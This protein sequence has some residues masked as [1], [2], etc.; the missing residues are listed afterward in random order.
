MVYLLTITLPLGLGSFILG[1]GN[2]SATGSVFGIL[3][4]VVAIVA[5]IWFS[6]AQGVKRLHDLDKSGW[7]FLLCYI[8]FVGWIFA[9]YILFADGTVG[10][11][12]YGED[13]KKRMPY[14]PQTNSMNIT[15]NLSSQE[16]PQEKS[17]ENENEK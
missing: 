4:G 6:L 17:Q 2:N 15:V 3:I 16:R 9:L 14:Q 7:L 12:R 10:P 1:A 13:P 11:N 8:P 5:A